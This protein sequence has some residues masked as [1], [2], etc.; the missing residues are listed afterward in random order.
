M[1][2]RSSVPLHVDVVAGLDP[3]LVRVRGDLDVESAPVL[4]CALASLP[5]RSV[6]VDLA[7][8]GFI[9]SSG[10]NALLVHLRECQLAGGSM[11]V[12]HASSFVR[13]VLQMLGVDGILTHRQEPP[14]GEGPRPGL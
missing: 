14:E 12:T 10:I 4:R 7:E 1:A 11:T 5:H 9:D 13:R 2:P 3:A 6:E 8:V